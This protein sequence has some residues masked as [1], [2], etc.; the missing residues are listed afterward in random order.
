MGKSDK[1]A[2]PSGPAEDATPLDLLKAYADLERA[3]EETMGGWVRAI[4]LRDHETEGHSRR[5]SELALALASD[6]GVSGDA[7]VHLRRG[8]LLHDVGKMALPDRILRKAGP[9][10][11]EEIA[12]VREHPRLAYEMLS[13]I[14]FLR[15]ALDVPRFHHEWWDGNGYPYGLRGEEI[16]FAARLF[17][18]VDVW[19]ALRNDRLYR[20]AQPVSWV[21]EHLLSLSGTQFEPRVVEA[22]E[23][24]LVRR[25][26]A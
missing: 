17:A 8:A 9:L 20:V 3:Y 5:V 4:D 10:D 24:L 25:G 6:L 21:K 26:E 16:P 22:F 12:M 2:L 13:G 7:L 1:P 19:D 14:D 11:A 15:P 18:V 23:S